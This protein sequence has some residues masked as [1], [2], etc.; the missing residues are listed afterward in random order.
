MDDAAT[1]KP[2]PNAVRDAPREPRIFRRDEP[3]C[4]DF[5]RIA[6]LRKLDLLPI[7]EHR[8]ACRWQRRSVRRGD[9]LRGR[10]RF[11]DLLDGGFP[12]RDVSRQRVRAHRVPED[13]LL[14]PLARRLVAHLREEPSH[15]R[16]L[17]RL[18]RIRAYAHEGERHRGC[19]ALRLAV[20][21]RAVKVHGTDAEV[22]AA[23]CQQITRELIVGHVVLNR[24]HHPT[25]IGLRR[26]RPEIDRKLRLD[27]QQ[28]APLHGPIHRELIA[29]EQRLDQSTAFVRF[30]VLDEGA[31]LSRRRQRA[32][33]I[34]EGAA[35]KHRVWTEHRFDTERREFRHHE[36]VD[37]ARR[38]HRRGALV[39]RRLNLGFR[40]RLR[41]RQHRHSGLFGCRGEQR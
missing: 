31:R 16:E 26:V 15:A 18:P 13:V 6:V 1:Q 22:A 9:T 27:A 40:F 7:R 12:R 32:D 5:A 14:L 39:D 10:G 41:R 38:L 29:L 11:S 30:R 3:F 33:D 19:Y 2:G 35:H 21:H 23:R 37:L 25:V 24:R 28:I 4:E 8:L 34:E 17:L 20:L 36:P